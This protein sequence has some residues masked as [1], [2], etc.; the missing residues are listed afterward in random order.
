MTKKILMSITLLL[1]VCFSFVS[2]SDDKDDPQTLETSAKINIEM[3]M[4]IQVKDFKMLLSYLPTRQQKLF[5]V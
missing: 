2:C 1:T 3:P 5:I 4:N